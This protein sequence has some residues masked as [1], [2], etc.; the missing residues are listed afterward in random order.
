MKIEARILYSPTLKGKTMTK[1][2][3]ST[4]WQILEL[5]NDYTCSNLIWWF[6]GKELIFAID[7]TEKFYI[8]YGGDSVQITTKNIGILQ[9]SYDQIKQINESFLKNWFT[10]LFCQKVRGKS[11]HR[12]VIRQIPDEIIHLFLP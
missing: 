6:E 5:C 12:R 2:D 1:L 9:E 3:S 11:L 4:I 10:L 7:C 8:A